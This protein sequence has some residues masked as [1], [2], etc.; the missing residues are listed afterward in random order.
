MESTG[1]F[2]KHEEAKPS[3]SAMPQGRNWLGGMPKSQGSYKNVLLPFFLPSPHKD[4]NSQRWRHKRLAQSPS[5]GSQYGIL[6]GTKRN[7]PL[8]MHMTLTEL[9]RI[10]PRNTVH[11]KG[12]HTE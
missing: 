2:I 11:L 5:A 4:Q 6:F 12:F 9:Q 3:R 7:E 1:W 10:M 8:V